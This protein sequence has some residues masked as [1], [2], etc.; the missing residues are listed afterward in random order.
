M[1]PAIPAQACTW[2]ELHP[3]RHHGER[4]VR[5]TAS[6]LPSTTCCQRHY[7][8]VD[9]ATWRVMRTPKRTAMIERL[10]RSYP[11]T[12]KQ[13]SHVLRFLALFLPLCVTLSNALY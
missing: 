12:R 1:D 13:A 4:D 6:Q 5:I 10:I 9:D 8:N 7:A 11:C 3:A 2:R